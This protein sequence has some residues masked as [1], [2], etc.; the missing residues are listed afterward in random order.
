MNTIHLYRQWL[1]WCPW[2]KDW[3]GCLLLCA[4]V[5]GAIIFLQG[6]R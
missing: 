3:I 2:V 6:A 5:L 1:V 4:G